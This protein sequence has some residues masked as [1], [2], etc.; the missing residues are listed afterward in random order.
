MARKLGKLQQEMLDR[1]TGNGIIGDS[2]RYISTGKPMKLA[3]A[4][5]LEAK[6]LIVL[7][8]WPVSGGIHEKP[9]GKA[10]SDRNYGWSAK[11]KEQAN[12]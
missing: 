10:T 5:E 11:L 2:E 8:V 4:R 6:G 3:T 7:D 1:I 9:R 12:A